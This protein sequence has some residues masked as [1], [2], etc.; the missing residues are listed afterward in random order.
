MAKLHELWDG[1]VTFVRQKKVSLGVCLI[2]G[3][4]HDFDGKRLVLRFARNFNM[5]REQVA[6]PQSVEFLRTM[7]RKYFGRDVDFACFDEA[8]EQTFQLEE[9]ARKQKRPEERYGVSDEKKPV[10]KRILQEF[11]GE[12]VR[13]KR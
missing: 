5:Q 7:F 13:Y 11:D 10:V 3:K 6:N 1:F 4:L 2:A 8:E 12:I 9:R